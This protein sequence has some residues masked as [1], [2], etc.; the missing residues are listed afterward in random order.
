MKHCC[1]FYRSVLCVLHETYEFEDI[2]IPINQRPI[3]AGTYKC[4]LIE[5]LAIIMKIVSDED[6]NYV[7]AKL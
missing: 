3:V 6:K 1:I 2:I 7:D 4:G 5:I